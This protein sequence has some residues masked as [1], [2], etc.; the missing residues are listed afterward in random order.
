MAMEM[1]TGCLDS[2]SNNGAHD[3]GSWSTVLQLP[4]ATSSFFSSS[5]PRGDQQFMIATRGVEFNRGGEV[6]G[7]GISLIARG[8]EETIISSAASSILFLQDTEKEVSPLPLND[9]SD[10]VEDPTEPNRNYPFGL[11]DSRNSD[12]EF[13]A[14]SKFIELVNDIH[15]DPVLREANLIST[16]ATAVFVSVFSAPCNR[17]LFETFIADMYFQFLKLYVEIFGNYQCGIENEDGDEELIS[18]E[19]TQSVTPPPPESIITLSCK[20]AIIAFPFR[21]N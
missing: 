16:T 17:N 12:G 20:N 7:G 21:I 11:I 3:D 5:T 13:F 15:Q 10:A 1:F 6:R 8:R 19:A 18:P 4:A 14:N 9:I 2:S